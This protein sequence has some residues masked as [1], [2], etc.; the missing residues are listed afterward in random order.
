MTSEKYL[1]SIL[2]CVFLFIYLNNLS[3][4]KI[5]TIQ[6]IFI[7]KDIIISGNKKTNKK[8][9]LKE[10][11]FTENQFIDT[12]EIKNIILKSKQNLLNLSLFNYVDINYKIETTNEINIEIV[13][14]ER[15]YLWPNFIFEFEDRN[16]NAWLQHKDLNRITF[17]AGFTKYNFR[18]MNENLNLDLSFGYKQKIIASYLNKYLDIKRKHSIGFY[19]SQQKQHHINYL[20][21]NNKQI[22]K[23]IELDFAKQSFEMV[24]S[25]KYRLS[26]YKNYVIFLK[27]NHININD[28][29]Y[30]LNPL[31]LNFN[32]KVK[33]F[34]FM[35]EFEKKELN[36]KTYPTTGFYL[37]IT[38]F[39]IGLIP[40]FD[41]INLF[42]FKITIK[43]LIELKYNFNYANQLTL[44]FSSPKNKSLFFTNALGYD[45]YVRGFEYYVIDGTQFFLQKNSLRFK[46]FSDKILYLKFIPI[47]KFNKIHFTTYFTT[48]CDFGYVKDFT[49]IYLQHNN[50]M[51]NKFIYGYGIG[52]DFVTYYDKVIRIEYSGNSFRETG[53]FIDFK[54]AF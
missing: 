39:K 17:G 53:V 41:N 43:K 4:Q 15:W 29:I 13:V 45:N 47:K 14:E 35:S 54:S 20:T 33:Y 9:I 44:H 34:S 11:F 46:F 49:N 38:F 23:K 27:Y 40:K 25:Y 30:D 36:N 32:K 2:I 21:Q 5:D 1:K 28:S 7:I 10:L 6:N 19:F 42:Y 50:F 22:S 16:I 51:V 26:L 24:F 8:I 52:I 37:K 31:C 18:G 3:A 48:F 12:S